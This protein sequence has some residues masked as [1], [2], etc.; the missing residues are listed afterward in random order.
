MPLWGV[1]DGRAGNGAPRAGKEA[2][3]PSHSLADRQTVPSI[4]QGITFAQ[5]PRR[6]RGFAYANLG[7]KKNAEQ[8][9]SMETGF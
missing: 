9:V 8:G 2:S 4:R 7:N 6:A 3:S 1:R 5:N